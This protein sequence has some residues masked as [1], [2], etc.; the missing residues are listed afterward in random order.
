MEIT[1]EKADGTPMTEKEAENLFRFLQG[2][3]LPLAE[4]E[5]EC[6]PCE[7]CKNPHE[8]E[9]FLKEDDS[10]VYAAAFCPGISKDRLEVL[11]DGTDLIISSEPADPDG[12]KDENSSAHSPWKCIE[13]IIYEGEC[14]L[15]CEIIAELATAEL[16]NGVLY[17]QLPKPEE[18]KP[19]SVTVR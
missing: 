14:E 10:Y 9:I 12:K 19:K 8:V 4:S 16:S 15:P 5:E 6:A 13:E 3:F 2:R 11:I 17:I 7:L 18:V 1:I